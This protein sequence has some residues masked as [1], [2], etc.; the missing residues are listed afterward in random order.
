MLFY[1]IDT[2]IVKSIKRLTLCGLSPTDAFLA[3]DEFVRRYGKHDLEAF[4]RSYE[5]T[6]CGRNTIQ[7]R[8]AGM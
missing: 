4:V 1:M 7:I 6:S 2:M 8:Q 5:V 3:C